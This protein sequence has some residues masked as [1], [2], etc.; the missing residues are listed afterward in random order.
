MTTREQD[1]RQVGVSGKEMVIL[2]HLPE[3]ENWKVGWVHS[4]R[5]MAAW[6][7]FV[8][9]K[10]VTGSMAGQDKCADKFG[11][12]VTQF[13]RMITGKWQ[14]GGKRKEDPKSTSKVTRKRKLERIKKLKK[15]EQA[16]TRKLRKQAKLIQIPDDDDE[17]E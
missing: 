12:S 6:L 13:K 3:A 4:E 7:Y 10:Q 16:G 5:L 8:L 15:E 9:H 2:E 1:K 11:C 17:E 14:E